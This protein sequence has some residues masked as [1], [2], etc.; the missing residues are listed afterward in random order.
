MS[1]QST[2]SLREQFFHAPAKSFFFLW[3]PVLVSLVAEPLTGL[4]DTAFVARLG[5]EAL[6]ALG[7]GT[8]VLSSGL[9]LFNF[10]SVGSQTEV[11]QAIGR[12]EIAG[13]RKIASLA[14]LLAAV[15]GVT[16]SMLLRYFSP[17][18][19]TF[20]GAAGTTHSYAV[21]YIQIRAMGMP[22]LL[23]MITATGVLYGL[24]DMRTPLRV[25]IGVNLLNIILDY[26]LIF[27]CGPV[28]PLGIAGAAIASVVSQYLGAIVCAAVIARSI[29]FTRNIDVTHIKRLMRIGRDMLLRTGSMILFMLLATRLATGLGPEAGALHQGIRQVWVFTGFFLDATAVVAQSLIGFYYGSSA[30]GKAR[31]IAKYVCGWSVCLGILLMV[32]M[33]STTRV[34][35]S[36]LVPTVSF[37]GF[38]SVWFIAAVFQPVAAIAFVTDGIHWGTGDFTY[39]RNVVVF[40]T[41]FSAGALIVAE[42][43]GLGSVTVIWWVTGGWI[44]LRA[45]LGI[46]RIWPG[47]RNSPLVPYSRKPVIENR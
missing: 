43:L 46:A 16:V 18:L 19:T 17:Q 41:T 5:T 42:Y 1:D 32:F 22:A 13:G 40:A 21:T 29:G 28:T 34:F 6:A 4:V 38:S 20:M 30:T 11:S 24:G 25:A 3:I 12:K 35:Y 7:V 14:L 47:T 15:I 9:W 26:L 8:V 33:F 10:L 44:C 31:Q 36:L 45:A 27:G 23:F 39:L 37:A 2:P